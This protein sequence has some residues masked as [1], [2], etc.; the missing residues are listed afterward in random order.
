VI[1]DG[2]AMFGI[3]ALWSAAHYDAG[4][5]FIVMANGAYG[6]MDAQ[7]HARG[8]RP[9]W[10][11]FPGLDIAGMARALGC[12]ATRVETYDELRATLTEAIGGLRDARTPLLVEA[13]VAP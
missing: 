13:V 1:G 9:A 2:S 6:V 11:Q 4:V 3:Q 7:A 10:P 8:G 12:P 5:L